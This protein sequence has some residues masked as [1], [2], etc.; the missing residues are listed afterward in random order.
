MKARKSS[1]LARKLL[2]PGFCIAS[3]GGATGQVAAPPPTATAA[4]SDRAALG[5]A[6]AA[7]RNR[8]MKLLGIAD[9]Q[10]GV[11]CL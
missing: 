4:Q 6:S 8:E 2:V 5:A 3:V 11:L 1:K 7:E 9:M 10:P